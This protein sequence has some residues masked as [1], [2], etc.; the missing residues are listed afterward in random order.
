MWHNDE[1]PRPA[2]RLATYADLAALPDGERG[3]VLNGELVLQPSPTPLHQSTMGEIYAELR[4]PFQR[5]RGG[6]GGWWLIQDVDVEFGRHDI[7]RPDISGWRRDRVPQFPSERPVGHRPDWVCEGLSPRTA[8]RDQGDK[9]A[10]YQRAEV[11][12]YWLVDPSNR[13]ITVLRLAADGYVVHQVAGD[14][15]IAALQPFDA[16]ELD[17]SFLF[18]PRDEAP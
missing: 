7:C 4:N 5:Q 17:L 6:P 3:E 8:L 1:V 10:I 11:P 18:P 2:Q 9:R 16:I 15:G 13:T 12:W 14:G